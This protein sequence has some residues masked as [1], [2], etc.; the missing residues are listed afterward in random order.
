MSNPIEGFTCAIRVQPMEKW[1]QK[2][3]GRQC[4]VCLLK[5]LVQLYINGLYEAKAEKQLTDLE[6]VWSE[7]EVLTIAK[8]MDKIKSEVG[9]TL[10]KELVTYDC[11]AQSYEE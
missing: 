3:D 10:K 6:R 8:T 4:P 1:V 2:T 11:F 9:D 7:A 5:P